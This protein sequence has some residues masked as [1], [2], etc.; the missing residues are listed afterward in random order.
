MNRAISSLASW[1]RVAFLSITALCFSAGQ[2]PRKVDISSRLSKIAKQNLVTIPLQLNEMRPIPFVVDSGA[3]SVIVN[4]RVAAS[5]HLKEGKTVIQDGAGKDS[6]PTRELV[7]VRLRAESTD[8][9][10]SVFAAP[11]EPLERFARLPINGIAGGPLFLSNV[12]SIDY[13]TRKARILSGS[14]VRR[15]SDARI[16]VIRS[17]FHCC[18]VDA[19]IEMGGSRKHA[20]LLIDT[21][22]LAFEI[23]LTR[24]FAKHAQIRP[25]SHTITVIVPGFCGTTGLVEAAGTVYMEGLPATPA[26]IF[27]SSDN[28]GTLSSA[29]FDGVIGSELLRHFGTVIFDAPHHQV[30]FRRD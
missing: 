29:K 19:E 13:R 22:A 25:N 2:T 8:I 5:F 14:F 28:S 23:V 15:P 18:M 1:R 12:V 30:L 6:C 26:A 3:S 27:I 11:L 17:A 24:E 16:S 21:G 9:E 10:S 4:E 7:G 20:R